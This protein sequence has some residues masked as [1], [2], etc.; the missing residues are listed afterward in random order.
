MVQSTKLPNCARTH[1]FAMATSMHTT[2]QLCSTLVCHVVND[3][4][5]LVMCWNLPC[6]AQRL[7]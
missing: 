2:A 6:H 1:S 4:L 5:M 3:L 7:A